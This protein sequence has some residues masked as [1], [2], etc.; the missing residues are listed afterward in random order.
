M[1]WVMLL[2]RRPYTCTCFRVSTRPSK[3]KHIAVDRRSIHLQLKV[4]IIPLSSPMS[5]AF[6]CRPCANAADR[7]HSLQPFDTLSWNDVLPKTA[8]WNSTY[9]VEGVVRL[10]PHTRARTRPS[11]QTAIQLFNLNNW[12]TDTVQSS[13]A[14][15]YTTSVHQRVCVTAGG[16]VTGGSMHMAA[17]THWHILH[18]QQTNEVVALDSPS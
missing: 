4:L 7:D 5:I 10:L 9:R 15:K 8:S 14:G 17:F 12:Q 6:R 1:L 16:W 3:H 18:Y 2:W 13:S 11:K